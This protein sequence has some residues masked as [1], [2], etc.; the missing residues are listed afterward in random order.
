WHLKRT[1]VSHVDHSDSRSLGRGGRFF[2]ALEDPRS[3]IN[4]QHPCRGGGI[5]TRTNFPRNTTNP[6]ADGAESG[7]LAAPELELARLI[8]AWPM[9]PQQS[10]P[11]SWQWPRRQ[12]AANDQSDI[13]SV[14][15][16]NLNNLL[17]CWSTG[18]SVP[19][20][21]VHPM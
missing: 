21:E 7:A 11:A 18:T 2:D 5:R 17:E 16:N 12:T 19:P 3:T 15:L 13:Y 6:D 1:E 20:P 4:R 8:A 9:L 10:A 14:N